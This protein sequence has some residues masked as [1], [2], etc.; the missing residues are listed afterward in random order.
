MNQNEFFNILMDGLKDFPETK[1]SGIISYY[2]NKFSH[3]LSLGQTEEEIVTELGN[4]NLIVNQYRSEFL[5]T[6]ANSEP[7]NNN[8]YNNIINV[9]NFTTERSNYDFTS[10]DTSNNNNNNNIATKTTNIGNDDTLNAN[11]VISNNIIDNDI[12]ST[13]SIN[14]SKIITDNEILSTVN[15]ISDEF[16]DVNINDLTNNEE[17]C[18]NIDNTLTDIKASQN[19]HEDI[20]S[21]NNFYDLYTSNPPA[22]S[23]DVNY[24]NSK[25]NNSN[26]NNDNSTYIKPK[27]NNV[28]MILKFCIVGV[29]LLIFSPV[30]TGIITCII[31]LLGVAISILVGSIGLL[32]GGTFTSLVGVPNLPMF[33]ANFPYPVIVLF[34]LGSISL[35]LFLTLVFYY[36]CKFFVHLVIKAYKVLKVKGGDI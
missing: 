34:S 27:S 29:T 5:D 13:I 32:V 14:N 36:L 18:S 21:N 11:D 9:E 6:V 2:D 22:E 20:N 4:P 25:S 33:V 8:N 7:F 35:S 24:E 12:P 19:P 28:N 30:I 26:Y 31:G 10:D 23:K 3:G 1:L 15:T 17:N 16:N